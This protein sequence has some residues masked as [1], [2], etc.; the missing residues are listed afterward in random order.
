MGTAKALLAI[1][2]LFCALAPLSVAGEISDDMVELWPDG[3]FVEYQH[4]DEAV[5]AAPERAGGSFAR[6]SVAIRLW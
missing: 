4:A 3:R 6:L 2:L 5:R 1:G